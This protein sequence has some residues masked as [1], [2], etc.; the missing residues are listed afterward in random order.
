ME[1]IIMAKCRGFEGNVLELDAAE[2]SATKLNG[3]VTNHTRYFIKLREK[4]GEIIEIDGVFA[5]DIE[6]Q[7]IIT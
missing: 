4:T 5:S 3:E 1:G 2:L 6:I 7:S